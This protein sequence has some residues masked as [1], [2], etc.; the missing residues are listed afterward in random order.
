M[1]LGIS[2]LA[3]EPTIDSKVGRL[4]NNFGVEFIDVAPAK[5]F[6][7]RTSPQESDVVEIRRKWE[8]QGVRIRGMQSLMFGSELNLFGGPSESDEMLEWLDRICRIGHQLGAERLV[9]GAPKNRNR[10]GLTAEESES[11]AESFFVRLGDIALRHQVIVCLEPNPSK[12]GANFLIDAEE[13]ETFVRL[14]NHP[15]IRM[16]FDTGAILMN[17]DEPQEVAI[18]CRE[19]IAHV[20]LSAPGLIPLHPDEPGLLGAIA[21]VHHLPNDQVPTIEMLTS[22]PE[23]SLR[24][25]EQSINLLVHLFRLEG[26]E[27]ELQ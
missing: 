2:N 21:A 16:Q 27:G 24:E 3:W 23:N 20:H 15:A 13:T 10:S 14:V 22:G 18:R 25:I 1:N 9:F 6:S 11:I 5:Y 7:L 4:L 17:G 26:V 12:Y 8:E 19:L